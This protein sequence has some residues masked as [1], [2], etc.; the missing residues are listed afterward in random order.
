MRAL[1]ITLMGLV[2]CLLVVTQGLTQ[3][4]SQSS[5]GRS[6]DPNSF[7]N[8]LSQGKDVW[9]KSET[10]PELQVMFDKM[11]GKMGVTDGKIT[12]EQFIQHM[13]SRKVGSGDA[14]RSAMPPGASPVKAPGNPLSDPNLSDT[15]AEESFRRLD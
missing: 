10:R 3:V 7:F 12:R 5:R 1:R 4:D 15:R 6:L 8:S 11:A 2:A 9:L 14:T 13:E